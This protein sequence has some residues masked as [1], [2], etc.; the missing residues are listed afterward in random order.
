M[1]KTMEIDSEMEVLSR[2][3]GR[4][5]INV[6]GIIRDLG[7][8]YS[9]EPLSEGVSG[10]IDLVDGQYEIRV[11]SNQSLQRRRF[12]AAHELAHY[13]LHRDLLR[14]HGHL[15]RL[16]DNAQPLPGQPLN[17][18]HEV[19]ANKLAAKILMP[20]RAVRD[21]MVWSHY[22]IT[23]LA[24]QF[25]VSVAAMEVRLKVLG[26]DLEAERSK[27]GH[28]RRIGSPFVRTAFDNEQS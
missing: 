5:P 19:E 28:Y 4:T 12:T 26:I 16:F 22:D 13:L 11:N 8:E 17:L 10:R 6:V 23:E 27:E 18:S 21:E 3:L 9:E 24:R 14:Q 25:Q 7:I 1:G 15:D 20:E 2:Y